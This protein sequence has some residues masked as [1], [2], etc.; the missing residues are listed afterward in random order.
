MRALSWE[1]PNDA[2][3]KGVDNQFMLGPSLLITPVLQPNVNYTQGV[4]PGIAEGELWYDWYTLQPMQVQPQENLTL[5]APLTH[6]NVHVRGGS[7]LPLQ[8]PGNTTATTKNNPYSLLIALDKNGEAAGSL[9][10]DDGVSLIQNATKLVQFQYSQNTLT[11][12]IQGT[13]HASP[14]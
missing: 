2:T 6:I 3:L 7:V 9:Y 4:F 5:D 10:L 14:R 11:T 8:L 13:Y 1:F 12:S